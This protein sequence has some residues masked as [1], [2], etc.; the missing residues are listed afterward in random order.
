MSRH[1]AT[2]SIAGNLAVAANLDCLSTTSNS[3]EQRS[4]ET[5]KSCIPTLPT[6]WLYRGGR[7][8]YAWTS[9]PHGDLCTVHANDTKLKFV[10]PSPRNL[11]KVQAQIISEALT[12][13]TSKLSPTMRSPL[14]ER[15]PMSISVSTMRW[16]D[17]LDKQP[18][19]S[20]LQQHPVIII[21][22]KHLTG[23]R[24]GGDARLN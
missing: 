9:S 23:R 12:N 1:F 5:C 14:P 10:A 21:S 16:G 24:L 2:S 8:I 3:R 17:R 11:H 4:T 13:I 19:L 20:N 7:S 18:R 22:A 15:L 6:L